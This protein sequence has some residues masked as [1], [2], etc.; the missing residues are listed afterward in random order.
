MP[1]FKVIC[2]NKNQKTSMSIDVI[3]YLIMII[4]VFKGYSKGLI[5]GVFSFI[6]F[7]IGL[8]AALKLSAIVAHYLE[9]STGA[10]GKW[11]P[12][13]SFIIVFMLVVLIVNI[14]ARV[15]K[16][17][18]SFAML[19]WAD[20]IGGIILYMLIYTM[21][22][23]VVLFFGEKTSL[24]SENSIDNSVIIK[25]VAPWGPKI[26]DSFGRVVPLFKDMFNEL[27]NF[28]ENAGNKMTSYL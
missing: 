28:F 12:V 6:A 1:D 11:L 10:S 19:G 22:F 3:F 26:I 4:A 21:I 7:I 15:L 23:S 16:K 14:G 8:A 25:Y 27:Q 17:T 2:P 18:I 13:L 24:I 20:K 5:I 9:T